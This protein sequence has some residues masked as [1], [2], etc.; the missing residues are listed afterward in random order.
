M[1]ER[2][3]CLLLLKRS[4]DGAPRVSTFVQNV[5]TQ[6]S[7]SNT[8]RF[9]NTT[10]ITSLTT[11]NPKNVFRLRVPPNWNYF[12]GDI[13]F[14]SLHQ[15]QTHLYYTLTH[16]RGGTACTHTPYT[17]K[18][19]TKFTRRLLFFCAP[20]LFTSLSGKC[21]VCVCTSGRQ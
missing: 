2:F 5:Y 9:V 4:T 14:S 3:F 20:N 1:E 6:A 11:L 10:K 8:F 17:K 15:T 13:F 21:T 7:L 16:R 19:S 18:S 12:D